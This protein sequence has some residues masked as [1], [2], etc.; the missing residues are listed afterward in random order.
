M[1]LIRGFNC[2]WGETATERMMSIPIAM[3]QSGKPIR[4]GWSAAPAC[5]STPRRTRRAA[6]QAAGWPRDRAAPWSGA[7]PANG[8]TLPSFIRA[9]AGSAAL[10]RRCGAVRARRAS[11]SRRRATR[12]AQHVIGR[13]RLAVRC[14]LVTQRS[15]VRRLVEKAQQRHEGK[16]PCFQN[17]HCRRC[18]RPRSYRRWLPPVCWGNYFMHTQLQQVAYTH[19]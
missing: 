8:A 11:I 4:R 15:H 14:E 3:T 12:G 7:A 5:R 18:S 2:P 1:R 13:E 19:I 10:S 9:I 16:Q 6:A 17:R